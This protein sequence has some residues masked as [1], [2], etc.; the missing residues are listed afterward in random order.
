MQKM[1]PLGVQKIPSGGLWEM[2]SCRPAGK[3]CR[4]AGRKTLHERQKEGIA[5]RP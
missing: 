2:L 4:M 1:H 5:F 3:D